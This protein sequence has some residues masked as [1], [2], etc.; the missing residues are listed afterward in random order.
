[1][2]GTK[3]TLITA[4]PATGLCDSSSRKVQFYIKGVEVTADEY[5]AALGTAQLELDLLKAT[6]TK[7][8]T[9]LGERNAE[10]HASE[11][12]LHRALSTMGAINPEL[13]EEICAHFKSHD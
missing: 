2:S 9:Q 7:R 1:M 8:L 10:L 12:L 6:L 3:P 4:D 11:D 5:T 13:S